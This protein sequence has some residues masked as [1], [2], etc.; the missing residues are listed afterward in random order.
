M[1]RNKLDEDTQCRI[2]IPIGKKYR[3]IAGKWHLSAHAGYRAIVWPKS[4]P[5][6]GFASPRKF[7]T[8][9]SAALNSPD[10]RVLISVATTI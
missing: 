6:D 5:Q 10:N 1:I 8:G 4:L 2:C 9:E 3:K 7:E